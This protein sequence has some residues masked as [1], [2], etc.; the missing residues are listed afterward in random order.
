MANEALEIIRAEHRS[1]A[2]VLDAINYLI[3]E[4]REGR[5]Q[6][7]F[8]LYWAMIHYIEAFPEK[9]HHPKEDNYLF[10]ALRKRTREA[11]KLLDSLEREHRGGEARVQALQLSLGRYEGGVEHGFEEF[12]DAIKNF[13]DF[14]W[15]HMSIE[16]KEFMPLTEKHLTDADWAAITQAFLDNCDPMFGKERG[17]Q[18]RRLFTRIVNMAPPPIGL[19]AAS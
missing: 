6:P 1:L 19:G 14:N 7:D 9:L 12:S 18:F 8:K 11:D 3:N 15:R 5:M 4:I 16:E 2:A 10:A 13:A 17:D